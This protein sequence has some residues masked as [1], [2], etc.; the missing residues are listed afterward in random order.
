MGFGY[1]Q[2]YVFSD[3]PYLRTQHS[4]SFKAIQ[5]ETEEQNLGEYSFVEN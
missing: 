5:A 4:P 2:R 3:I 1:L